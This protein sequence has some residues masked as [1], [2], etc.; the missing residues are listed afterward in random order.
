[1]AGGWVRRG[2]GMLASMSWRSHAE[3]RCG[4]YREPINKISLSWSRSR[5]MCPEVEWSLHVVW[6]CVCVC[7]RLLVLVLVCLP[8]LMWISYENYKI[9]I[10]LTFEIDLYQARRVRFFGLWLGLSVR[11]V[12]ILQTRRRQTEH[13]RKAAINK[14]EKRE[15]KRRW[16]CGIK[17][18]AKQQ[19]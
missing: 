13:E 12:A 9:S 16:T 2:E 6:V 10:L 15:K 4:C 8:A 3:L 18:N 11:L 17:Q 14:Q 5:S 1:M 7:I 19:Q